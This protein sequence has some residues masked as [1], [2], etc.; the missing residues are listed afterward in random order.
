MCII[1]ILLGHI[2]LILLFFIIFKHFYILVCMF[3]MTLLYIFY[4]YT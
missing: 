1:D 4:H 3:I 2:Y